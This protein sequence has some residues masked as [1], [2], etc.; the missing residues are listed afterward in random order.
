MA[1]V[2]GADMVMACIVLAL[3]AHEHRDDERLVEALERLRHDAV[4]PLTAGK[5]P[6]N[7]LYSYGPSTHGRHRHGLCGLRRRV[8][9]VRVYT[10]VALV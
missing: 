9:R 8:W 3:E 1:Y 5:T 6:I 2:V 10:P 7:S 4:G